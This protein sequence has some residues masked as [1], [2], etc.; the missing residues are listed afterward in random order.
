M[1]PDKNAYIKDFYTV[2]Q[3]SATA[4][5]VKCMCRLNGE[6]PLFAAHFPGHPVLPGVLLLKMV[7]DVLGMPFA[8]RAVSWQL[9]ELHNAKYLSVINPQ[10]TRYVII[11]AELNERQPDGHCRFKAVVADE[12]HRYAVFSLTC[13]EVCRCQ[14]DTC[15]VVPVYNNVRTVADVVRS[16]SAYVSRVLVVDDGSTD[17]TSAVLAKLREESEIYEILTFDKNRGK[18]AVLKVG[19]SRAR[20][21]G[22][23]YAVTID[24]DGQHDPADVPALLAVTEECPDALVI[25]SR[26][27]VHDN[28]P[29]RSTFANHFSN[30]WFALQTGHRLPDTQSGLRV[31]PLRKLIGLRWLTARYEAELELLVLSAWHAVPLMPVPVSVHYPPSEERVSHFR[32]IRDFARITLLNT[33]LCMMAVVYGWPMLLAHRF[34]HR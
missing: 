16:V 7:I 22:F 9:V 26:R 32:P 2:E 6:S 17:G 11:D 33:L 31:Y 24:A 12:E 30:F 23:R 19:L 5:R 34:C 8:H 4:D 3:G 18:G 15:A 21:Y 10:E 1:N 29:G 13:V 27:L 28:M 25:G 20:E 14:T